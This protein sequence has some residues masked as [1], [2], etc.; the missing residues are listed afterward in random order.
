MGQV[1]WL[2]WQQSKSMRGTALKVEIL[3]HQNLRLTSD[4]HM[5][6][7]AR[8]HP[9]EHSHAQYKHM[10]VYTY[11]K[12]NCHPV[13]SAMSSSVTLDIIQLHGS[14]MCCDHQIRWH[15]TECFHHH[16]KLSWT[17]KFWNI[18][19]LISYPSFKSPLKYHIPT[20][21]FTDPPG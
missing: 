9:H 4:L 7:C 15:D 21:S 3:I 6:H 19:P 8:V 5:L 20:E 14:H 12:I 2:L 17:A 11:I 13:G 18:L 16:R 10:Y 1:A